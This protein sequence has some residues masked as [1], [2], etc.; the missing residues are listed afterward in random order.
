MRSDTNILQNI[1][2]GKPVRIFL[3]LLN[4]P[5][6]VRAQC[7]YQ[8]SEP[9]KFSLLFK[10]GVLPVEEVDIEKPCI[11]SID[12]GGPTVSLEAMIQ[13]I[14][15]QQTLAMIVQKSISHDQ[16]REYFRVDAVTRVISKSFQTEHFNNQTEPWSAEGHTVDI[17]GSGILA[18]FNEKPQPDRPVTLEIMIPS[19]EPETIKVLAHQIRVQELHDGRFEVAYHFDDIT[20]EDRDKIIGCC[21]VIQRKMLRLKVMVKE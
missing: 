8:K 20:T 10:S 11:I 16:M 14:S 18:I 9:P 19:L 17:S 15:N 7:L 2:D 12:M 6:R 5:E 13:K 4:R 1:P 3:P 21:L